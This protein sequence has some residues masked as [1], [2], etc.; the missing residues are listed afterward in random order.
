VWSAAVHSRPVVMSK[1]CA[2]TPD[3][4]QRLDVG[5][6]DQM[7][8]GLE[9]A[10]LDAYSFAT[11]N[12][13]AVLALFIPWLW[14]A[15]DLSLKKSGR[16]RDALRAAGADF[17]I[18]LQVTL[19]NG[20]LTESFRLLVQRPRPFVYVNPVVFGADPANYT[21]FYSGHTSFTAAAAT[22]LVLTLLGRAAPKLLLWTAG[23][24]GTLLVLLTAI[25][26]VLSGRHFPSDVIAGALGGIFVAAGVAFLHR[27]RRYK[28]NGT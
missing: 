9:S 19:F 20:L 28:K 27:Q 21:S 25:F 18:L 13:M 1:Y 26:R 14:L 17:V 15:F 23:L 10:Q 6:I 3:R 5:F 4:C 11:Q 7:A 8:I 2:S 16:A 24:V 12:A 22:T